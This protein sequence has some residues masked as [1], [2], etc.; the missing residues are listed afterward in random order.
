[1]EKQLLKKFQELYGRGRRYSKLFF[2]GTCEILSGSIRIITEDM[3]FHV[4]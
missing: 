1:M 2:S 3:F 4:L